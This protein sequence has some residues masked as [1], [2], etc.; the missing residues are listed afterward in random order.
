[1]SQLPNIN[2]SRWFPWL[3]LSAAPHDFFPP[4]HQKPQTCYHKTPKTTNSSRVRKQLRSPN[5]P[6]SKRCVCSEASVECGSSLCVSNLLTGIIQVC[7]WPVRDRYLPQRTTCC[8]ILYYW[9]KLGNSILGSQHQA[10]QG[11]HERS[12][13]SLHSVVSTP[14]PA[15]SHTLLH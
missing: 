5:H 6:Q 13:S 9:V 1:M 3:N 8:L 11:Q 2:I 12:L 7:R 14:Q 4:R 15:L 10:A